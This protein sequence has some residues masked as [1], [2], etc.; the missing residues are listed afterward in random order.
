MIKTIKKIS[1]IVVL[2]TLVGCA[3]AHFSYSWPYIQIPPE[4]VKKITPLSYQDCIAAID[5]VLSPV[6]KKHFKNQDSSIA[7][8]ELCEGI[9]GFFTTNW[10]LYRYNKEYH[11]PYDRSIPL[12]NKPVNI[13]SKFISDGI[14]HPEAMIRI[15]F[16]CYYKH[17]NGQIFSWQEEI[18]KI[19]K[20][21]PKG[22]PINYSAELPDSI[23]KIESE[24]MATFKFQLLEVNDTVNILYRRSSKLNKKS[25]DWY[26]LTGKINFKIPVTKSINIQILEIKS[27]FNQSYILRGV[28]TIMK[29]DTITQYHNGWLSKNKYYFNY[30]RCKEYREN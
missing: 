19:K 24:I 8:I 28:D 27:E 17:L 20:I 21:W 30:Q 3:S 6:V 10:G 18:E 1:F 9:G 26:Y 15:M 16:T 25:S 14:Y 5:D 23:A 22:D 12:P 2:L 13:A 7:V 29:G 4:K 11:W